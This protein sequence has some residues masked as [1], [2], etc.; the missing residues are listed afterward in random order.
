MRIDAHHHL[1]HYST[2]EYAWI[3]D[4]MSLLRKDYLLP[5]LE[6][7]MSASHVAAA[8]TVQAR[9]TLEETRWLLGLAEQT[10][11]I[12]GVVG[13]APIAG[14]DFAMQMEPLLASRKLVGLRHIVQAEPAGFLDQQAFHR[15]MQHITACELTYD[16]LVYAH[17]LEEAIRFVDRHPR[18]RFVLDHCG[19][20]NLRDGAFEPWNSQIRELAKRENVCCKISGLVTEADWTNWTADLLR[21]YVETVLDAFQP[22][23]CMAGS[24]WPVVLL[25]STYSGWWTLLGQFASELSGHE[26][27]LLFGGS[28]SAFYGLTT[29]DRSAACR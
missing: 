6:N 24:D 2:A 13:W 14:E 11:R 26:Q 18:Q 15:G 25:A 16:L 9:Q 19:K 7:V 22:K 8:V 21:P 4:A 3:S 20:P 23:R 29:L 1:W 28:A 17:Q 27:A 5:Q 12:A 10:D